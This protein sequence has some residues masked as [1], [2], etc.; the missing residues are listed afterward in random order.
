MAPGPPSRDFFNAES[1]QRNRNSIRFCG[2]YLSIA[3][4]A[5]AGILGLTNLSGAGFYFVTQA[6][7]VGALVVKMKGSAT[8]YFPTWRMLVT[9]SITE[10]FTSYILFWTL[11][12]NV[13]HLF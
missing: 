7:V 3:G 9:E 2:N 10:G 5:I 12:Y 1:L 6:A 4:G 13:C 8:T 11:A